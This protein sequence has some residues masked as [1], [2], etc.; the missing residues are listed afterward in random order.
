MRTKKYPVDL[1]SMHDV[2]KT[3]II[4]FCCCFF[5]GWLCVTGRF[6]RRG[7]LTFCAS[8]P[9]GG[10]RLLIRNYGL[11]YVLMLKN[12]IHVVREA[13]KF[14]IKVKKWRCEKQHMGLYTLIH[15]ILRPP[16]GGHRISPF[17]SRTNCA[18][19]QKV[20]TLETFTC[21]RR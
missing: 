11:K 7:R 12:T 5:L 10:L 2:M 20:L 21:Y 1:S 18:A 3:E 6:Q 13:I 9:N 19:D 4:L 17:S 14:Y 15:D 16:K 8:P